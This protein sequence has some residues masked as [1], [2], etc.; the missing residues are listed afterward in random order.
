MNLYSHIY[1]VLAVSIF[2][3]DAMQFAKGKFVATRMGTETG[4]S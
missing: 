2:D 4:S 1:V 3:D